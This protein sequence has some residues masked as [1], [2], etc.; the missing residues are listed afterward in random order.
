MTAGEDQG[1]S[2]KSLLKAE[3][4]SKDKNSTSTSK[5]KLPIEIIGSQEDRLIR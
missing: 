5:N 2:R 1:Y 3:K 4:R